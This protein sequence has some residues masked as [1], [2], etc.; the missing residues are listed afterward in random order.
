MTSPTPYIVPGYNGIMD[1]DLTH[2][3]ER[4]HGEM[5]KIHSM[6]IENYKKEQNMRPVNLRYENVIRHV[7][8]K[9]DTERDI[10]SKKVRERE[11]LWIQR[12]DNFRKPR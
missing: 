1:L 11:Q 7:I 3:D 12:Y 2:I 4:E 8:T 5:I 6:D 9:L 10:L